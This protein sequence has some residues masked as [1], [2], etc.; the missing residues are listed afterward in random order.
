M[1]GTIGGIPG[2]NLTPIDIVAVTAYG[3]L[4]KKE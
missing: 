1:R 2:D 4:I 3:E